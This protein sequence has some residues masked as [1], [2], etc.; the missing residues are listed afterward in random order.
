[1]K[2]IVLSVLGIAMAM[3][4]VS[5]TNQLPD[6]L[7]VTIEADRYLRIMFYNCENFFDTDDDPLKNDDEF[8]PDGEKHWTKQ[9]FYTKRA[10]IAQVITA[11]GGWTPPDIVGLCEIESH[12]VMESLVNQSNLRNLGYAYLHKESPDARGIDVALLYQPKRFKPFKVRYIPVNVQKSGRGTRDILMASGTIISGDT[13][14]V[15]VNHW[16]SR[17]GGQ[18]ES[19]GLRRS[20]AAIVRANVDSL[21]TI[22]KRANVLIMGDLNDYP[23]NNS[24]CIDLRAQTDFTTI[25][26]SELYNLAYYMQFVKGYGTHK[27]D[28]FWGIL[29]QMII[30]GS[31]LDGQGNLYTTKDDVHV[32][33]P[34]FLLEKD[35]ANIG[36]KPYRTYLGYKYLG[37]FSDHLPVFL[38][39]YRNK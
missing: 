20:V 18:T 16:P 7:R 33:N 2:R 34:P 19:D 15:F 30:S 27:Y 25:N 24:V 9:R 3:I 37:G 8:I 10:Q 5:Q 4:G 38:N 12:Y 17:W 21:I 31:L 26:E 28:G 29:D 36:Y 32:F 14:H 35:E 13:L 1:M 22:N 11:I 23:N 6:D 39:I